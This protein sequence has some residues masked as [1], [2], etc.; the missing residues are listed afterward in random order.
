M[1][2][3]A[4]QLLHLRMTRWLQ[5]F[6][7]QMKQN[8]EFSRLRSILIEKSVPNTN[9]NDMSCTQAKT[10]KNNIHCDLQGKNM[11]K[12]YSKKPQNSHFNT[13]LT[14]KKFSKFSKKKF[15]LGSSLP[16][17]GPLISIFLTGSAR[18]YSKF[19]FRP[20]SDINGEIIKMTKIASKWFSSLTVPSAPARSPGKLIFI[21][22]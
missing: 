15:F 10:N 16:Q 4:Q 13:F 11:K 12:R 21:Q 9:N 2:R 22:H 1:L 18:K 3:C 5:V 8:I 6:F 20:F 14:V 7:S 19:V 17:G